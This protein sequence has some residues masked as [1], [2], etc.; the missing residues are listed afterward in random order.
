MSRSAEYE[1]RGAEIS[2]EDTP[3]VAG[4]GAGRWYVLGL[5][6]LI[7][8]MGTIDRSVISV[9]AEPLKQDFGL[10]DKQI[11]IL[12]GI[13]YSATY[14]LAVLPSGWL[15]DRRDRRAL[16]SLATAIWSVFTVFGAISSSF[17]LLVLARMGV[18][19]AEAP[20]TPGS[21]S[22]IADIFP[23]ERRNTAISIYH[24]AAAAGQIAI[25]VIG[26]W[27]L[28][29]FG[30]TTVFLVAGGPGLLLA[31]LLRFTTREPV[32]GAFDGDAGNSRRQ[33]GHRNFRD[34]IRAIWGNAALIYAILAITIS[35]GVAYSVTV[36]STSLLVR[37]HHM[38]VS[39]GAIW[40]GVGFGI[41]M[42]IGTLLAGP[43]ADRFS[44]GDP[45]KLAV[46]PAATIA[47]AIAAGVSMLHASSPSFALIGLSVLA[48]MA[49]FFISMGYSLTL[50]LAEPNERGTT[51]AA[52]RLISTLFGSGMI[53]LVTGALSDAIGGAGS[54][55]LA[56]LL[57]ILMLVFSLGC[58]IR[59][60]RILAPP[61]PSSH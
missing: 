46:I 41:C 39:Q 56:L 42:T 21:F 15:V 34:M 49:G 43:I 32:R 10:D 47:L 7:Y 50:L 27:L 59:I 60:C 28:M 52:T 12:G 38:T 54:I 58:Y 8:A 1:G 53:P 20:A 4:Q 18:G 61:F 48:F 30:W 25:F 16:L 2:L 19:A 22:I 40:T 55:R 31:A 24:A 6:T 9:V 35:S 45:R 14:A 5:L 11:G 17:G 57:T 26:G 29:H 51:M 37:I 23:K 36:W 44:R 13:A 3:A 33:D